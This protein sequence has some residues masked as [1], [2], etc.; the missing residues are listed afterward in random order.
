LHQSRRPGPW[1]RATA[2]TAPS[3]KSVCE[4]R[5]SGTNRRD[6]PQCA[7]VRLDKRQGIVRVTA[8]FDKG[9]YGGRYGNTDN[10]AQRLEH[11]SPMR[12]SRRASSDA[13]NIDG[14]RTVGERRGR[15]HERDNRVS[16]RSPRGRTRGG[17]TASGESDTSRERGSSDGSAFGHRS[18]DRHGEEGRRYRPG[19]GGSTST[20][21]LSRLE[22]KSP[23]AGELNNEGR[24][25]RSGC[26]SA[27]GLA[28]GDKVEARYRGRGTKFYK[29]RI[30]RIN[31]DNTMDIAYDDGEQ[32][33]GI[34]AEHVRSLEPMNSDSG[35]VSGSKMAKGDRVEAR[36]RGKGTRFYKG[37]ISRVNSDQTFDIAYDDGEKE[38]GIAAEHVRSLEPMNSDSGGVSGSKMAK[39]DRVEARYRGKGTRFYKGKISRVNSDQTFDI[40][41]DDGE[42]EIGI[43][44]EHVRS[45][46]PAMIDGGGV[47]GSKMAKGDRV[48][49]RY[50]EKGTR[51]YKGKISRVNS[52]QTFDIAYDDG[53]QEIGI[54]AEH[55]R[56]LKPAMIDGGGVSGS[57]MARGDRVE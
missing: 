51:F 22:S 18:R 14:S 44:A 1:L 37:K 54:A 57:K 13:G 19:P 39:G 30:S 24:G 36:Y 45:L 29:G 32:E 17:R 23:R 49:A 38:I 26:G 25:Q 20:A 10:H 46:E 41:Y 11:G 21:A 5:E 52:D 48:E 31:S 55:V 53:E 2:A 34:A 4:S 47:S 43:A 8:R 15:S 28:R 27:G 7:R 50:R 6:P 40:A 16:S 12:S 9:K 35:G 56:S 42:K 33:I 3:S